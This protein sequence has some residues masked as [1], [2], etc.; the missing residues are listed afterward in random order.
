MSRQDGAVAPDDHRP[1]RARTIERAADRCDELAEVA[2]LMGDDG[3]AAGLRSAAHR[4]R[5]LALRLLD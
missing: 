4:N 2:E 1:E 5:M 3:T